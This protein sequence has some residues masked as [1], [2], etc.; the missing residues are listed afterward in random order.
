M[1]NLELTEYSPETAPPKAKKEKDPIVGMNSKSG[2]ITFN[3]QLCDLM[4][5]KE[6]MKVCLHQN[7][8]DLSN[9]YLEISEDKGFKAVPIKS[10]NGMKFNTTTV[11][12][13]LFKS[14]DFEEKMRKM[15]VSQTPLHSGDK[16]LF[17][18]I[19]KSIKAS[20]RSSN[21]K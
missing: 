13:D 8:K 15:S 3:S 14:I 2:L 9:W 20:T 5:L 17:F 11:V 12:R 7:K 1:E 19:T 4:G 18:I 21:K 16:K 6:G 10:G